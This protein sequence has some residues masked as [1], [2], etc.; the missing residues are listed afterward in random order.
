MEKRIEA[1]LV[2][3]TVS[4]LLMVSLERAD[5]QGWPATF[6]GRV[7]WIAGG[8]MVV[9]LDDGTSVSVDLLRVP[10]YQYAAL[11]QGERILVIGVLPDGGR[12]VMATSVVRGEEQSP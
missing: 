11:V 10:Q 12:R 5:A 4:V 6:D 2:A 8:L 7:Q 1:L 9:Q 3:L